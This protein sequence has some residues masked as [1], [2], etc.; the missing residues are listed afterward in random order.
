VIH[1]HVIVSD[2]KGAAFGGHLMKDSHVC[3][4]AELVIIEALGV[5]L[6]RTFDE[7]T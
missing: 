5:E 3:A 4:T 1:A 2:A 7:K 6:R